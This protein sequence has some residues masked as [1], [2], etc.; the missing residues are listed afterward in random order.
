MFHTLAWCLL[1]AVAAWGGTLA[2][3]SA[4]FR[5]RRNAFDDEIARWQAEAARARILVSQMKHERAIWLS[6]YRQGREDMIAAM[7][8]V[9]AAHQGLGVTESP[10]LTVGHH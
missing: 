1:A 8:L 5:A 6:G 10:D 4:A 7:P 9:V 2:W 3:A